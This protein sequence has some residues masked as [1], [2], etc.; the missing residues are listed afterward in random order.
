MARFSGG[1][2]GTGS[3]APGPRGPEG[4]QG[5]AG[6]DGAQ[7]PA[8]DVG[9]SPFNYQG[10]FD[11]GVTYGTND[12]VTFEG[13]LWKLNNFIGAAGY[14]PTPGQW[15]LIIPPG[16]PG[17]DGDGSG[18]SGFNWRGEWIQY[19]NQSEAYNQNDAVSYNGSSYFS[20]VN[21][22]LY[23][24]DSP[25]PNYWALLSAKGEGF[26][27][28]GTWSSDEPTGYE[29]ND[30]V[31]YEGSSYLRV[32]QFSANSQPPFFG[33]GSPTPGPNSDWDLI[34]SVG[35]DGSGF[36]FRDAWQQ[37][38]MDTL[39]SYVENDIVTYNGVAYI[40]KQNMEAAGVG[41][42]G[43]PMAGWKIFAKADG[44][45]YEGEWSS[46][47]FYQKND[48]VLYL[49]SLYVVTASGAS[50][51]S[52]LDTMYNPPQV[53]EGWAL[54][55]P[56]GTTYRPR[57]TWSSMPGG[58]MLGSYA[59]ND[60]V[61]YNG[62]VYL[63][64]VASP[65]GTPGDFMG[66]SDWTLFVPKA[67]GF[68]FK[69]E[70]T[71]DPTGYA[72]N[73]I[74]TYNGTV[75]IG[76]SGSFG[77]SGTPGESSSWE[78]FAPSGTFRSSYQGEWQ[79]GTT[80]SDKDIVIHN[81][82]SWLS[83]TS[84]NIGYEPY[85]DTFNGMDSR[86]IP[87]ARAGNQ[88]SVWYNGGETWDPTIEQP[89]GSRPGDYFYKTDNG[90]IYYYDTTT[91]W[92]IIGNITGP[93]GP[94]AEE[95]TFVVA[96]GTSGDQPTFDG[97]PLF[98]GS[99]VKNGSLVTFRIN[100][101]FD[102]I[103]DFGTGQYYVQLPFQSKYGISMRD[104]CLHDSNTGNEWHITGHVAANSD[105]L[106]LHY[107]AGTGQDEAFDYNSPISLSAADSFHISGTYIALPA[108]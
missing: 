10:D 16:T 23:S 31:E 63:A 5:P 52:P 28:R 27:W 87:I 60:L 98:D 76:I 80:Y 46:S 104:G 75:W 83:Y 30:V 32:A 2:G 66:G 19:S 102:N 22:N 72:A 38:P 108:L 86:W 90:D 25:Q 49:N 43:D 107:T 54:F 68:V 44:F 40:A 77:V 1:S 55:L 67:T 58:D 17:A 73:D 59:L 69:G 15:S 33:P 92:G 7:G 74:V 106:E 20:T 85:E 13:G 11:Y 81:G 88:G 71:N 84:G 79:A 101:E 103:T 61:I 9:P 6:A 99:Y 62:N 35:A 95:T 42:P 53:R 65:V 12:A 39:G 94:A 21:G 70:W 37:A 24:P 34:A 64:T 47:A 96:G 29:I 97:A 48:V 45:S 18:A 57:G 56:K 50:M 14:A 8:G 4:P 26:N 82:S 36:R 3:G 78:V 100:V 105:V 41:T 93:V 91:G 51:M 89:S